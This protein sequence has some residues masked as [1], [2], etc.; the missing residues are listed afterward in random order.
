MSEVYNNLPVEGNDGAKY[1][2]VVVKDTSD[3]RVEIK[4]EYVYLTVPAEY[5]CVYHK[6]LVYM[7]DFGKKVIDDCTFS[8]K[9]DGRNIYNCWNLFQSACAAKAIGDDT[10]AEFYMTYV[11]KQLELTYKHSDKEAYD[12]GYYYP[13][14]PDGH[15]KAEVSCSTKGVSFKVSE[16]DYK[17]LLQLEANANKG[18]VFV[19]NDD[20]HL[21]VDKV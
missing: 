9:G 12:G 2:R 7:A 18:S 15:I 16:D 10:K 19:L 21:I 6:L 4:P 1:N 13:V 8:C 11:K 17:L 14:T 20:G 3:D 5:V